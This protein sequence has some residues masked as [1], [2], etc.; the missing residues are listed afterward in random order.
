[1]KNLPNG[2]YDF[3]NCPHCS[4]LIDVKSLRADERQRCI[5]AVDSI[6]WF[7]EAEGECD[8]EQA[9]SQ[10]FN[11]CREYKQALEKQE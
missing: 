11:L 7:E 9:L 1:M 3:C 6:L 10:I 4:K 2:K 5:D 8:A